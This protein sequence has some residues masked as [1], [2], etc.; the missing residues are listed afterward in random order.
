MLPRL[1]SNSWPEVICLLWPLKVRDYRSPPATVDYPNGINESSEDRRK[2]KEV[3]LTLSPR[4]EYSG[5]IWAHC[6]LCLPGSSNSPASASRH[7]QIQKESQYIKYLCCDDART[8]NQWV[9]G[10]RIAKYGKTLYDNYQRAVAKAGLAS[11][12]VV[13]PSW[14]RDPPTLASQSAGITG[15]SHQSLPKRSKTGTPQPNGQM[16]QAAHSVSAVLQEAQTRTETWKDKKPALGNHPQPGTPR[17]PQVPKSSLPPPPPARRSSDTSGSPATTPKAK[18]TGGGGFLALPLD[19][20]PPPPPPPPVDDPELPPP[21][22]DFMEPPPA[23]V[24]PP[25]PSCAG[26]AGSELP[27]PPPPPELAPDSARPP[28]AVAKRPPM[29]PK[30]H[31]NPA[32]P[33]GAEMGVSQCCLGC[34]LTSGLKQFFCIGLPQCWDYRV[35]LLLPRLEHDGTISAHCNLCLLGSSDSSASGSSVAGI[36][37]TYHQTQQFCLCI[38][39]VETGFHHVGQAGLELLTSGDP[40]TPAS[41]SACITDLEEREGPTFPRRAEVPQGNHTV[42]TCRRCTKDSP[43]QGRCRDSTEPSCSSDICE[44]AASKGRD[45]QRGE[46]TGTQNTLYPNASH[47]R[48][49]WAEP[50]CSFEIY[51]MEMSLVP[52]ATALEPAHSDLGAGEGHD[53]E[54][55]GHQKTPKEGFFSP[56]YPNAHFWALSSSPRLAENEETCKLL[57]ATSK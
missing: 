22:G 50:S 52:N 23:F 6:N 12:D 24:P 31:E 49:L 40:P 56:P 53:L 48:V 26:T 29:P 15:L 16:P 13:S 20:L 30:R 33:G 45:P 21:P 1:V 47:L 5:A 10:I 43:K 32:P 28:P 11:R 8:L 2:K 41:Q 54:H 55:T 3:S 57:P 18:G 25:P 35:S 34:S 9:M 46:V 7:P 51:K 27:P 19:F 37:V 39:L 4:L 44:W 42:L 17:A 38:F 14:P 36:T